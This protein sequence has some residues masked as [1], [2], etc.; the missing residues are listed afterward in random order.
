MY[1]GGIASFDEVRK[2]ILEEV[3][4][5]IVAMID[6]SCDTEHLGALYM[7]YL[8]P[9]GKQDF[10]GADEHYSA[11]QMRTALKAAIEKVQEIQGNHGIT[12]PDNYYNTCATDGESMVGLCYRTAGEPV[13]LYLS[14]G[15]ADSL[16]RKACY[17]KHGTIDHPEHSGHDHGPAHTRKNTPSVI[18]WG[19][20]GDVIGINPDILKKVIEEEESPD[21]HGPHVIVASEPTTK[22]PG[23]YQLLNHEIVLVDTVRKGDFKTISLDVDFI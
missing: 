13:P 21:E 2:D 9:E 5:G 14:V 16:N 19:P 3:A 8:C 7:T 20:N 11:R 18:K 6:G 10:R 17:L 4:P 12:Q 22:E 1:N 23:W 15:A